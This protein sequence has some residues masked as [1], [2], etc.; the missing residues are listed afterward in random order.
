MPPDQIILLK[1]IWDPYD[2]DGHQIKPTAFRR[3]DLSGAIEAHVSADHKDLASR[4][5]MEELARDQQEKAAGRPDLGR[6][7]AL[8]GMLE[9]G[10]VRAALVNVDGQEVRAF[11][12]LPGPI[13]GNVA[14][15]G[16]I[17]LTGHA[18]RAS[19]DRMRTKL[20]RL[21]SPAATFD[22]AYS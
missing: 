1:L 16:I 18:G 15:C 3:Q 20:A 7:N 21:A 11:D 4:Q 22:V 8:I 10:A 14:H 17:N 5:C 9:C 12:V 19:V 2:Y 6:D 13:D